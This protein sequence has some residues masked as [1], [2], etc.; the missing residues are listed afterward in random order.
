MTLCIKSISDRTSDAACERCVS[1]R[2]L[3][4]R[5]TSGNRLQLRCLC[6]GQTPGCCSQSHTAAEPRQLQRLSDL[7]IGSAGWPAVVWEHYLS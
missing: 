6:T 1:A 7:G 3:F 4:A 5:H 2:I